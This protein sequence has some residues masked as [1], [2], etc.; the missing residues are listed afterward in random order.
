MV[1]YSWL[2]SQAAVFPVNDSIP[3]N[4]SLFDINNLSKDL[5]NAVDGL[6][7]ILDN[8]VGEQVESIPPSPMWVQVYHI[9]TPPI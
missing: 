4:P 7:A 5:S 8:S 1:V 3:K 6:Y 2:P 9:H